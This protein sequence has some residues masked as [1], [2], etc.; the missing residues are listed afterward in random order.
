MRLCSPLLS[1]CRIRSADLIFG[2]AYTQ[3][4]F[5][6]EGKLLVVAAGRRGIGCNSRRS[7]TRIGQCVGASQVK[8]KNGE[9]S[10]DGREDEFHQLGRCPCFNE[11][12]PTLW[13]KGPH[14]PLNKTSFY[15]VEGSAKGSVKKMRKKLFE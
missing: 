1:G 13:R 6:Y 7:V 9:Q 3:I 4:P 12:A 5:N 15:G 8:R 2:P 14:F 11:R 10:E